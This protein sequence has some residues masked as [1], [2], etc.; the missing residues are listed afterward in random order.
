M[1]AQSVT[2]TGNGAAFGQSKGSDLMSLGAGKII[3][4]HILVIGTGVIGGGGNVVI[5]LQLDSSFNY[6]NSAIFLTA[7][8]ATAHAISYGST[9]NS[10]TN[11]LT[12][13]VYG[14]AAD[15]FNY[16]LVEQGNVF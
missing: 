9:Y 16:M 11:V 12:I 13:T 5:E 3:G 7:H 8:S 6:A 14:T 10:T 4:P 2:G 1:V 15:D